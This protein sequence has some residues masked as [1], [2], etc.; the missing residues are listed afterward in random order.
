M[1]ILKRR[2]V[3]SFS[4][5]LIMSL[6]LLT[7]CKSGSEEGT[8]KKVK[9][10]EVTLAGSTSVTPYAEKIASQFEN[11]NS[12]VVVNIQGLGSTAGIKAANENTSD[13]GMASRELKD[14]EKDMGLDEH[15]I[16]HEGIAVI[17]HPNNKI[18]DLSL[19]NLLK[20]FKG[21]I[22]NWKEVGGNDESII[23]VSREAG[24]GTR[25]AF[26]ELVGLEVEKNEK[27][28]STVS[29][30]ALIA[31]GNGAIRQNVSGKENA[32]GY[33]SLGYLD[34]SVN[35]VNIEDVKPTVENVI[36][37]TYKISRPFL[38]LTKGEISDDAKAYLDF[39][40][41]EK[42]QAIIKQEGAVPIK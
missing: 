7:G 6:S 20:I 40:M 21:E 4:L 2:K 5:A 3:S 13:I 23:V 15:I 25:G 10:A 16:A 31:D 41:S 8:T 12:D 14:E 30:E 26:D 39:V 22:K 42:G 37:K 18:K 35:A 34:D 28:I 33:I 17:T 11:E 32:I 24:S 36:N 38:L 19:E 1:S 9:Q 29:P 27:K